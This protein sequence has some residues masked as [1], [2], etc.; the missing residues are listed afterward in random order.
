MAAGQQFQ[1]FIEQTGSWHVVN[2]RCHHRNRRTGR[3]IDT[4]LQF[5]GKT[6]DAQHTHRIFS[7]ACFRYANDAQG[8][9]ADIAD[10]VVVV[11]HGFRCRIVVHRVDG[12]VATRSIFMLFAEMVVTQY[13][14]MCIFLHLTIAGATEGGY[15]Q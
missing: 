9:A 15:F 3:L 11:Q 7:V 6:H 1:H 4:E 2:Q 10:T 12:K 13:T 14:A 8:F 5:G